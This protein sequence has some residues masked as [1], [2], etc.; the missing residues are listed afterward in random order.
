M[1]MQAEIS[2]SCAPIIIYTNKRWIPW[3]TWKW[4]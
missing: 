4:W 2:W 1:A 3:T